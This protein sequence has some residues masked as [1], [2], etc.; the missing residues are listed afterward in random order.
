MQVTND[1]HRGNSTTVLPVRRPLSRPARPAA[2]LQFAPMARPEN[3][4]EPRLVSTLLGH[5]H[6]EMGLLCLGS[7]LRFS[8]EPLRLR[9]H[10][11]GSLT[12]ADRERLAAALGE[13]E[14]VPRRVADERVEELLAARPAAR[15]FRRENP[16]ALKLFDLPVFAGT[17]EGAGT[18]KEAGAGERGSTGKEAAAEEGASVGEGAGLD[19]EDGEIRYCD[20][21]VLFLRPF[22]GLFDLP[23]GA[24]A[25]FMRDPQNAYSVRSWHLLREPRLRLAAH[26][27]SGIIVFRRRCFDLDLAEWFLAQPK[28]RFAPVW[29]EQTCWALLAQPAGCRLLDPAAVA[30]PLTGGPAAARQVALHFVSPVRGLLPAYARGLPEQHGGA[31]P[32][33]GRSMAPEAGAAAIDVGSLPAPELSALALAATEVRRRLRRGGPSWRSRL[34]A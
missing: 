9:V 10:D 32:G 23:A 13:P 33:D 19:A 24:G 16:L 26:V 30:I 25:L 5:A 3:C 28:Y 17:H 14:V 7:L 6:V 8:A 21:D 22:R 15:A 20:S 11:D 4:A 27:N 31:G 2:R 18:G 1:H 12:A 29:V 34:F